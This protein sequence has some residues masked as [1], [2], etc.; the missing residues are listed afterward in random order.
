M[1]GRLTVDTSV[2]LEIS[3][4]CLFH[5]DTQYIHIMITYVIVCMCVYTSLSHS[6]IS[7]LTLSLHKE[8]H[9]T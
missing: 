5:C 1:G 4:H 3:M 2:P 6:P 8:F 7:I 9:F